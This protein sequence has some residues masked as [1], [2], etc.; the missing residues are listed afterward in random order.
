MDC[1][2][3]GFPVHHQLP[4][5]TQTH[6]FHISDAIQPSHPVSSSCPLT[7]S[8]SQ[9]QGLFQWGGS[10][11]Q[12]AKVLSFRFQGLILFLWILYSAI[13]SFESVSI[14][15]KD[16]YW[17]PYLSNFQWTWLSLKHF[18]FKY[19]FLRQHTHQEK[20]NN[21]YAHTHK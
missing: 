19:Y 16:D 14:I 8:L 17:K 13:V 9:Q 21:I 12:A 2:T 10:L 3:P 11:H 15:I 18:S 1:S 7:F 4:E 6:V 20:L 5:P